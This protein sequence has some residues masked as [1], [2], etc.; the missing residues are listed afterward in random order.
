MKTKTG[1]AHT[2]KNSPARRAGRKAQQ[3]IIGSERAVIV[4][5]ETWQRTLEELEELHD[6]RAFQEAAA[7]PE[8]PTVEHEELCRL[9]GLCPLRYLRNRAGLTQ[10]QLSRKAGFSQSYIAKLETG[11]RLPS[12]RALQRLARAL[13]VEAEQLIYW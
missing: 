1:E 2:R 7:D 12:T 13:E 10:K 11:E 6:L 4:P 9:L 5:L 3:V 8:A